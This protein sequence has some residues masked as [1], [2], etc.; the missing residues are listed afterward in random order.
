MSLFSAH[1][2]IYYII[3]FTCWQ[4]ERSLFMCHTKYR[5]VLFVL[6]L[7]VCMH[8]NIHTSLEGAVH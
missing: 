6:S 2:D 1:Y 4:K 7:I 8:D 5:Y 3:V